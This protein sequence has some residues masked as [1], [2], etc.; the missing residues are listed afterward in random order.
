[1]QKKK[2][3]L[4]EVS[5]STSVTMTG[6][7]PKIKREKF[8]ELLGACEFDSELGHTWE[9]R[10]LQDDLGGGKGQYLIEMGCTLSPRLFGLRAEVK[11]TEF[12]IKVCMQ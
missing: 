3:V 11:A 12:F 2:P 1:M 7:E 6:G 5:A 4:Q 10:K 8:G 9:D